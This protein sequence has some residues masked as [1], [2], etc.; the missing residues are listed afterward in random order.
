VGGVR[1]ADE[2]GDGALRREWG[3]GGDVRDECVGGEGT[4]GG[5]SRRRD[6]DLE[7]EA[8]VETG[9]E[10]DS[11]RLLLGGRMGA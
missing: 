8:D 3:L 1:G 9:P 5:T 11:G 10:E 4:G 6:G 7:A 2:D